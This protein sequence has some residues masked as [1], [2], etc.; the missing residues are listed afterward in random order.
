MVVFCPHEADFQTPSQQAPPPKL[1]AFR[2]CSVQV[3]GGSGAVALQVSLSQAP[4]YSEC[5]S[6]QHQSG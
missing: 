5:K 4:R 3:P 1:L 6:A 2:H